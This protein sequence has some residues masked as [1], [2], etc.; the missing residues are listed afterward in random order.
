MEA[1]TPSL[2]VYCLHEHHHFSIFLKNLFNK[3]FLD[4]SLEITLNSA[5]HSENLDFF[6]PCLVVTW[7]E[8]IFVWEFHGWKLAYV[9][10]AK[11]I[12]V[13]GSVLAA[14]TLPVF[15]VVSFHKKPKVRRLLE[16]VY[17]VL[18]F[19]ITFIINL[20]LWCT[21]KCKD[22]YFYKISGLSG[23]SEVLNASNIYSRWNLDM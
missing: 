6:H 13:W 10:S 12:Q 5:G 22:I 15:R 19:C 3:K 17:L 11:D 16:A 4:L 9:F 14:P 18:H 21:T 20:V 2:M 1:V 23:C 8:E 7:F